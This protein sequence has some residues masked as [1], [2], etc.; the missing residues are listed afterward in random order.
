MCN[1]RL[2]AAFL[3]ATAIW[4]QSQPAN[5]T[6]K[7]VNP[8]LPPNRGGFHI[9]SLSLSTGAS[10]YMVP[11]SYRAAAQNQIPLGASADAGGSLS[12]GWDHPGVKTGVSFSYSVAHDRNL[13]YNALN[14]T[15]HLFEATVRRQLGGRWMLQLAVG[16]QWLDAPQFMYHAGQLLQTAQTPASFDQLAGGL[17]GPGGAANDAI[18]GVVNSPAAPSASVSSAIFGSRMWGGSVDATL[19]YSTSRRLTWYVGAGGTYERTSFSQNRGL[20]DQYLV[21]KLTSGGAKMGVSY[22][23]SPATQIGVDVHSDRVVSVFEDVY[24][25]MTVVHFGRTMGR[26]WFWSVAGGVG[27]LV[28]NRQLYQLPAGPQ[29]IA[30]GR[31]GYKTFTQTFLVAH[32]RMI[33][34]KYGY[35]AGSTTATDLAWSWRRPGSGWGLLLSGQQQFLRSA[36]TRR[37]AAYQ[38]LGGVSRTVTRH[39]MVTL[40]AGYLDNAGQFGADIPRLRRRTA[41]LSFVWIPGDLESPYRAGRTW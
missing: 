11:S 39:T 18:T 3:V 1:I 4:A 8:E 25:T 31:F 27:V 2:A 7:D 35:G 33:G 17:L 21:P 13:R 26:R 29:Y 41:Q 14:S 22:S 40:Q 24:R 10:Q 19:S 34:D 36:Q 16:G 28:P 15:S 23:L 5:L 20:L 9:Y 6:D 30:G 32:E 37:L 12:V 38:A